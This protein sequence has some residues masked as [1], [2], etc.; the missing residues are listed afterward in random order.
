MFLYTNGKKREE[1]NKKTMD[2]K[3]DELDRETA[4]VVQEHGGHNLLYAEYLK[5][6]ARLASESDATVFDHLQPEIN[7]TKKDKAFWDALKY[8][9]AYLKSYKMK[10]TLETMKIEY[11]DLP[12]KTGYARRSELQRTWDNLQTTVDQIMKRPFDEEIK[13]FS[14]IV[15]L[16]PPQQ[17]RR[18]KVP[19]PV[20]QEQKPERK[21]RHHRH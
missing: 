6:T 13:A 12:A 16:P 8:C 1:A 14:K 10:E 11:P 2:L 21:H 9:M 17:R 7:Y 4:R 19:P 5:M 15:G 18:Q 3:Q 20:Q